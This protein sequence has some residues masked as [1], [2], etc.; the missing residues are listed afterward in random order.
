MSKATLF[1]KSIQDAHTPAGK[2]RAVLG[3]L[4]SQ[5]ER[6][7]P[8]DEQETLRVLRLFDEA[9]AL[10]ST[11][12]ATGG[13]WRSEETRLETTHAKFRRRGRSSLKSLGGAEK[14]AALRN[15]H[16][17]ASPGWWWQLDALLAAD[18]R[19][20]LRRGG[21]W[22]LGILTLLLVLGGL[23]RQFLAPSPELVASVQHQYAAEELLDAGDYTSALHEI[24]LGL[25][26]TP[27]KPDM[28]IFQ[29]VL[30]ELLEQPAEAAPAYARAAQLLDSHALLLQERARV[31]LSVQ[32]LPQAQADAQELLALE[33]RSA[34]AQLYLGMIAESQ[35]ELLA[36]REHYETASA[37][38]D[39]SE[40]VEIYVMA[41]VQLA[42]LMRT[43]PLPAPTKKEGSAP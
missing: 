4:E 8:F 40:E 34:I 18:R 9:A 6:A 19:V 42:N 14:F 3:Q 5:L 15:A 39:K 28:L 35:G 31:Y 24:E 32:L 13:D 11:L 17:P 21:K 38:A 26:A 41:R 37:W 20:R 33:P 16:A 30:Y 1:A 29:G 27:D 43:I 12:Q 2:L 7:T 22:A 36:A 25:Q 10:L 23:Y